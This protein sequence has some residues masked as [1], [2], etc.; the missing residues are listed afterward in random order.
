MIGS[1]LGPVDDWEIPSLV[2]PWATLPGRVAAMIAVDTGRF[3]PLLLPLPRHR[4]DRV[5]D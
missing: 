5:R 3:R 4:G 1:A 2:G